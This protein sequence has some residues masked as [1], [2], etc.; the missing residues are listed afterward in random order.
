MSAH[1]PFRIGGYGGQASFPDLQIFDALFGIDSRRRVENEWLHD[2]EPEIFEDAVLH[3]I[4][5]SRISP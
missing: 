1:V 4:Q 2:F 3:R 5:Q